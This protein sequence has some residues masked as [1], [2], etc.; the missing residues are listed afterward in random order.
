MLSKMG[1]EDQ[2]VTGSMYLNNTSDSEGEGEVEG[3]DVYNVYI[4]IFDFIP[5]MRHY[6]CFVKR[7]LIL[8]LTSRLNLKLYF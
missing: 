7:M 3:G 6:L 8:L 2:R 4:Y 5:D 1:A